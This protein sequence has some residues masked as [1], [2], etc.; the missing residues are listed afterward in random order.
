[1]SFAIELNER[2]S[3]RILE[4]A[5]R[6]QAEVMLE[7]K[8]GAENGP[9]IGEIAPGQ[10]HT[11]GLKIKSDPGVLLDS[12]IGVFAEGYIQ[13]GECRY[14][15]STHIIDVAS[16]GRHGRMILARPQTLMVLQRRRFWRTQYA[17]SSDVEISYE[18]G[19]LTQTVI[20]ALCNI[21]PGGM[22]VRLKGTQADSL[23]IGETVRTRFELP[24]LNHVF[25]FDAVLCNKTPGAEGE[26][27]LLGL[28]FANLDRNEQ[29]EVLL[30]SYLHGENRT[31]ADREA[32]E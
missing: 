17:E 13:M 31:T 32:G 10:A 5:M 12:L 27:V 16:D 2:Q 19:P 23:L 8:L 22:A 29:A 11:I 3:N 26:A 15:F 1:M 18:A 28:Q 4:Q 6:R 9:I 24:N 14:L 20:G 7:T 25:K 21:S 30:R